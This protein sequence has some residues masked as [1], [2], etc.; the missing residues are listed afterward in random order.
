MEG[1]GESGR[2]GTRG[3][4]PGR[5]RRLTWD[6]SK[7]GAGFWRACWGECFLRGRTGGSGSL[8][9]LALVSGWHLLSPTHPCRCAWLSLKSFARHPVISHKQCRCR[10]GP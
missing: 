10:P 1:M 3:L 5:G 7:E 8:G 6:T 2:G 9:S 4:N